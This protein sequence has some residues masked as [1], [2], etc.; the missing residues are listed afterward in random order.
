[1]AI[2]RSHDHSIIQ[3]MEAGIATIIAVR[4]VHLSNSVRAISAADQ[5]VIRSHPQQ[6]P[7]ENRIVYSF[8]H[9]SR[10]LFE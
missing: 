9:T 5:L 3:S 10:R 2:G 6:P 7:A 8:I 4:V 1:M